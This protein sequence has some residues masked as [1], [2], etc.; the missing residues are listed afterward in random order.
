MDRN[1]EF[2]DVDVGIWTALL[3]KY[4]EINQKSREKCGFGWEIYGFFD[5]SEEKHT[6]FIPNGG[7]IHIDFGKIPPLREL[8]RSFSMEKLMFEGH[9][10][11]GE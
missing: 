1:L 6:V 2:S 4:K 5:S 10:N 9:E 3:E 7:E 8:A 11:G